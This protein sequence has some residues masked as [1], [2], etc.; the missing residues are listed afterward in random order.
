MNDSK[1]SNYV[2]NRAKLRELS[3]VVK[4]G[5]Q[6]G[7]LDVSSINEGL[8]ELYRNEGHKE[9]K[10]FH[11]WKDEGKSILKGSKAFLVWGSPKDVK[12][13][14]PEEGED[15]YKYWPLC[16]LFSDQQVAERN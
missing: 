3:G 13:Q 4:L 5:M 11:Q 14:D 9:F 15:E 2:E 1:K 8:I 12:H 16:Y 6:S 10:T 7:S